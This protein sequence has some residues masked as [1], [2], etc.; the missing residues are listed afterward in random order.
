MPKKL[1]IS[2]V[3]TGPSL[4]EGINSLPVRRNQTNRRGQLRLVLRPRFAGLSRGT[5]GPP[6]RRLRL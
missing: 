4:G 5:L 2:T 3:H 1:L 6:A